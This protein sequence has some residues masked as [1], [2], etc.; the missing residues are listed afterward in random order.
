MQNEGACVPSREILVDQ[1][2]WEQLTLEAEL[3]F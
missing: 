3:R 2:M 1:Y